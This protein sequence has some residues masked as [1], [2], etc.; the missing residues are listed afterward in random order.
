VRLWNQA[1][2]VKRQEEVIINTK[3]LELR[4]VLK[5]G[6]YK[7]KPT[8][9]KI[10]KDEKRAATLKKDASILHRLDKFG[11]EMDLISKY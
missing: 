5:K 4:P 7:Y 1:K 3:K 6:Y 8:D 9:F 2:S 10:S 11:D